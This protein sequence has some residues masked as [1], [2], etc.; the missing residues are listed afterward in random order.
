MAPAHI[1][2]MVSVS[3]FLFGV[4]FAARTHQKGSLVPGSE[5]FISKFIRNK[6]EMLSRAGTRI[7]IA[8]YLRILLIAPASL[9]TIGYFVTHRG[10]ACILLALVGLALPDLLVKAMEQQSA[11]K[12]EGRYAKSLEQLS[13]SLRAGMSIMQA[14]NDV[15]S[16]SFIHESIRKKYREMGMALKMGVPINVAFMNF[17]K[18][19]GSP[20]AEDVALAV[21]IQ[22]EVGGREADAIKAIASNI[23][24]RI[25]LRKEVKSIFAGTTTMVYMFDILPFIVMAWFSISNRSYS[26]VYFSNITYTLLFFILVSLT[27]LG[28]VMAHRALR[29]VQKQ[30]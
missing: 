12:F 25:M 17:A 10:M 24:D 1:I 19:T 18:G 13:S 5:D 8:W 16:C 15:A 4:Y 26:E 28:S 9:A 7:T 20:D 29:K 22:N 14:V 11:K 23:H 2:F 6:G 30:V 27:L 21:S 3:I